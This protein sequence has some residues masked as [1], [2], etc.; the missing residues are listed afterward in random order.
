MIQS[1]AV[2]K[3]IGQRGFYSNIEINAEDNGGEEFSLHIPPGMEEWAAS[4]QFGV[5]YF[6]FAA[7]L[8]NRGIS[9]TI[10]RLHTM[11]VD[12]SPVLVFYSTV[13]CLELCFNKTI[14]DFEFDF[15]SRSVRLIH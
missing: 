15:E 6:F 10:N 4:I 12:S 11:P 7:R 8:S 9:I 14:N 3:Q 13:K 1:Y 5:E 2:K